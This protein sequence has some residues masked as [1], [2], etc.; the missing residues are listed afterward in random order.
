M[1]PKYRLLSKQS[2]QVVRP[3]K[4]CFAKESQLRDFVA[5]HLPRLFHATFL[6][7]EYRVGRMYIDIVGI[8]KDGRPVLIECKRRR[9]AGIVDQIT[10]YYRRLQRNLPPFEALAKAE[11]RVR[12]INIDRP[13]LICLAK[14][15]SDFQLGSY[16]ERVDGGDPIIKN[17]EFVACRC[18]A[19][20]VMLLDWLRGTQPDGDRPGPQERN[21]SLNYIISVCEKNTL[22]FFKDLNA[23]IMG[24]GK[25]VFSKDNK[26]LRSFDRNGKVFAYLRPV[27]KRNQMRAW[28]KLAPGP[29]KYRG[30]GMRDVSK[31]GKLP[32]SGFDVEMLIDNNSSH[33]RK[34]MGLFRKAYRLAKS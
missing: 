9:G 15:F 7:T 33:R 4:D 3:K 24:L 8:T 17:I 18:F 2:N 11:S 21:N 12:R 26:M 20:N 10:S 31:I 19:N 13:R 22:K 16:D 23:D 6:D 27:P 5:Q 30:K 1:K 32:P 34:A 25:D 14:E 29:K 28:F